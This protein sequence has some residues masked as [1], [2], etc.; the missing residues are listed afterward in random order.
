MSFKSKSHEKFRL[1]WTSS[2]LGWNEDDEVRF[3]VTFTVTK[4]LMLAGREE[5]IMW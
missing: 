2:I 4:A 3:I 5:A 1:G